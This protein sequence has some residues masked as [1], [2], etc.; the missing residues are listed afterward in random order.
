M[1]KLVCLAAMLAALGLLAVSASG[2]A[3]EEAP[4]PSGEVAPA[5]MSECP[6]NAVCVWSGQSFDG[7]FSWWSGSETGCHNHADNP[8]I[9][10]A[11][12]RSGYRVRIGGWGYLVTGKSEPNLGQ[13]FGEVCWPE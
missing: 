4:L 1:R 13:V 7:S 9:G 10:S 2:A 5:S 3:A 11:W 6:S 8:V 12:N